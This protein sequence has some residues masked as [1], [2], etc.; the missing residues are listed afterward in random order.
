MTIIVNYHRGT[1]KVYL[2]DGRQSRQ[3]HPDEVRTWIR[4]ATGQE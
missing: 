1:A 3:L 2:S 4:R